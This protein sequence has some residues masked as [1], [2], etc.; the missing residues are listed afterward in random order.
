M[1]GRIGSALLSLV[2]LAALAVGG[3]P[4]DTIAAATAQNM[5]PGA[6]CHSPSIDANGVNRGAQ[7]G[8]EQLDKV[9]TQLRQQGSSDLD[10][11][12][13]LAD[14]LCIVPADGGV[15]ARSNI[16]L[17]SS[18]NSDMAVSVPTLS[19]DTQAHLYYSITKWNW[20]NSDW[21]QDKTFNPN[22][23]SNV[24]GPDGIATSFS[25]SLTM[26]GHSATWWGNGCVF[27]TSAAGTTSTASDISQYG[28]GFTFQDKNG[29]RYTT[30]TNLCYDYNAIH[31]QEVLSFVGPSSCVSGV[32]AFGTYGHT[33]SSTS[34]TGFSIGLSS[35][36]IAWSSTSNRWQ[37]AGASSGTIT[38]CAT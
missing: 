35:I 3:P 25:K 14:K 27:S 18:T 7:Y 23:I 33:W 28:V 22:G 13:Y 11:E 9:L 15:A 12:T 21:K 2:A 6:N 24:G 37:S 36:G 32:Q 29:A 34:L 26:K 31:G 17:T 4:Q 8:T 16:E 10:I 38:V 30:G 20:V 1:M 5:R 19:H